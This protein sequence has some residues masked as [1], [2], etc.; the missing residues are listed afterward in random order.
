[1]CVYVHFIDIG[2]YNNNTKKRDFDVNRPRKTMWQT[3]G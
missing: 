3:S 2:K 1:M